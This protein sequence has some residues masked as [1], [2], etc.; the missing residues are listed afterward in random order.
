MCSL[1]RDHKEEI[2]LET[3][4][5]FLSDRDAVSEIQW[6]NITGGEPFLHPRLF[7]ICNMLVEELPSLREFGFSTN[8]ILTNKVSATVERLVEDLPRPEVEFTV[9][10]S[11]DGSQEV[12]DHVRGVPG[13]FQK[14]LGTLKNLQAISR[15]HPRLR[16]VGLGCNVNN[17]T[18]STLD[19][20]FQT[21]TE[22]GCPITFTPAV[23]SDLYYQNAMSST[24]VVLTEES[25]TQAVDFFD[26]LLSIG[27]IDSYYNRFATKF[28]QHSE[29][30]TG[31]VFRKE[32]V[33]LNPDGELYICLSNDQLKLGSLQGQSTGDILRSEETAKMRKEILK[34]CRSCGSNCFIHQS[35]S[36]VDRVRLKME[37]LLRNRQRG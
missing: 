14:V 13:A 1:G 19:D 17:L 12:H 20:V 7:D 8:A 31:C 2:S 27:Q 37:A 32:G 21:A 18:V 9:E 24:V 28:M 11:L 5:K 29:R 25:Q 35:R 30:A 15:H 16:T 4:E 26:R 34:Y 3:I 33:F 23:M 6:I 10:L 22:L 36:P